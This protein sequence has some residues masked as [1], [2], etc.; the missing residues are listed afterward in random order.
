M[1]HAGNKEAVRNNPKQVDSIPEPD[2]VPVPRRNIV[3]VFI[4][5]FFLWSGLAKLNVA[6]NILLNLTGERVQ[7]WIIFAKNNR[8]DIAIK[9]N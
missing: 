5:A 8:S 4:W 9:G 1:E 7:I 3:C 2:Q 6:P